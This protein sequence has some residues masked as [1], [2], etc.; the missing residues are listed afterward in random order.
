MTRMLRLTL[1]SAGLCCHLQAAR[2]ADI[3]GVGFGD[4]P[5]IAAAKLIDYTETNYGQ[6][7]MQETT[8]DRLDRARSLIRQGGDQDRLETAHH[9][10]DN[11]S[12]ELSEEPG[13]DGR[14]AIRYIAANILPG[15]QAGAVDHE[16]VTVV[17]SGLP[18][19]NVAYKIQRYLVFKPNNGTGVSG[20]APIGIPGLSSGY[21]ADAL[22]GAIVAKLGQ[23]ALE[24]GTDEPYHQEPPSTGYGVGGPLQTLVFR[25]DAAGHPQPAGNG[26]PKALQRCADMAEGADL[27]IGGPAL[28]GDPCPAVLVVRLHAGRQQLVGRMDQILVNF[29]ALKSLSD[30]DEAAD[31]QAQASLAA[32]QAAGI[33]TRRAAIQAQ[34]DAAL[35][36]PVPLHF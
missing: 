5:G 36:G 15:Q 32:I 17:F 12:I 1:A 35:H 29:P 2:A 23:P 21:G 27:T 7:G 14:P 34:Q 11:T 24:T 30:Q 16:R 33:A 8:P 25:L 31:R 13:A 28:A 9:L 10:L 4:G 20:S 19:G 6:Y 3:L 26:D 22:R 18:S